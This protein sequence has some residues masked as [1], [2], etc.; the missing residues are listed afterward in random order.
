VLLEES[1]LYEEYNTSYTILSLSNFI[2]KTN[3]TFHG[4]IG[5]GTNLP[6]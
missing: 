3:I 1:F 6:L 5:N 2:S 4:Q